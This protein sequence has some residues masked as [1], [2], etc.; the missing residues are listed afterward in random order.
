MA[1]IKYQDFTESQI[2]DKINNFI[3]VH[4]K[5]NKMGWMQNVVKLVKE[6]MKNMI[7]DFGQPSLLGDL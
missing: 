6:I 2:N 4:N 1:N 5:S 7:N 3:D